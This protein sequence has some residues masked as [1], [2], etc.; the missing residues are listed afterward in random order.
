M[1]TESQVL[2]ALSAVQDPDLH[3]DIVSLGFIKNLK[4]D[5]AR[6]NFDIELTTPAC[7]VKD[8][9]KAQAHDAVKALGGVSEVSINMTSNVRAGVRQAAI[10]MPGVKN[11]IA[12]ASGKGGVGKSTASVNLALALQTSGAAVGLLDA[13][14]YGP[15][16]PGMLGA[17]GI[18]P[19]GTPGG[20]ILP[21]QKYG[22]KL[23]SMG[24]LA[25]DDTPV[26]WRGPM[27]HGILQQFLGQVEWGSL[28]Y[29]LIDLPPGT[30][31]AQLTLT[32][33]AP[34]AG[35]AIITTPQDVSLLIARKGLKMFQ[36][37]NVPVL[38]IVENMSYFVCSKCGERHD[39]FRHGGGRR[40]SE[41]LGI[42][43]LGEI[44]ID[45]EVVLGGDEGVPIVRRKP[46]SPAAVAYRQIASNMAAQL[47][48][49]NVK[50]AVPA[51]VSLRW[52]VP[53]QS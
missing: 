38:G 35:A 18:R 27:V 22:L 8:Q 1:P 12:V 16:I 39:I 45:P 36:K 9:L 51:D 13:D 43:F 28:D 17:A 48:I 49:Q 10:P 14:I 46:D 42:P 26:I 32:Q 29:L 52:K 31:D 53:T 50:D 33:S 37:V 6:V 21:I 34:L 19:E 23:M 25:T 41:E 24:F 30:G 40:A 3:R 44:P 11:V 2:N 20:K 4:I 15:S 47:S 5:G 7:P